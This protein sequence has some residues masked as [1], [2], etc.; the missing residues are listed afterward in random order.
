MST[1]LSVQ[2]VS[3]R[4]GG[5]LKLSG[6]S[7]EVRQGEF[8]SILGA[9]GAGK[10]TLLGIISGLFAPVS[11][12]VLLE[13]RDITA[14]PPHR[15]V[16]AGVALAPQNHP[17]FETMTVDENLAVGG[18]LPGA[19]IFELF[20]NLAAKRGQSA[21]RLSGGERQM[22]S[23]AQALLTKPRICLFDEPS[24]GLAPKIVQQV[25][26]TIRHLVDNG[27]TVLMVEQNAKTALQISDRAYVMEQGRIVLEGA[28]RDIAMNGHVQ[29][30]Y[31]GF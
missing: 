23:M 4:F 9:N 27:L 7:L 10:T 29:R 30:A 13:G 20:P 24:S 2:N 28:S 11:G 12:K 15:A 6:V 26:A 5:G 3:S 17:I 25:F 22:L 19:E 21:G 16:R 8:V 18:G 1:I 14:L 31:L